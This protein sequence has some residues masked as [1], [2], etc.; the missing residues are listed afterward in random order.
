[1]NELSI[2]GFNVC[3]SERCVI[4]L[5]FSFF[6]VVRNFLVYPCRAYIV[7]ISCIITFSIKRM[8]NLNFIKNN[9]VRTV[10]SVCVLNYGVFT[11]LSKLHV[12]N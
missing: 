3:L 4:C 10:F 7:L 6:L 11:T 5:L 8:L 1:M 9:P 12:L 2:L